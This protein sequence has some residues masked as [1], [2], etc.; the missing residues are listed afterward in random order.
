MEKNDVNFFLRKRYYVMIFVILGWMVMV[1]LRVNLSI[2][3]VDMTSEKSVMVGNTTYIKVSF[4]SHISS[5][6]FELSSEKQY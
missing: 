3:M 2:C 6:I 4:Y 5:K 1:M